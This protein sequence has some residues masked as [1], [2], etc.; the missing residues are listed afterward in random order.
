MGLIL[1]FLLFYFSMFK[2]C[3]KLNYINALFTT[4]PGSSYTYSWVSGVA[5]TGKFVKNPN[6]TWDV[7]GINGVPEGW[8]VINE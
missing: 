5:S 1:L 4:T 6:A 8:T 3:T 7:T 2:G